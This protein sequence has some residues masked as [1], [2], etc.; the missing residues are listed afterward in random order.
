M[1]KLIE[2]QTLNYERD[3]LYFKDG[4]ASWEVKLHNQTYTVNALYSPSALIKNGK[5]KDYLN[6]IKGFE[7]LNPQLKPIKKF[8]IAKDTKVVSLEEVETYLKKYF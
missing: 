7:I 4:F 1:T 8:K 5:T 2:F 6:G 3:N